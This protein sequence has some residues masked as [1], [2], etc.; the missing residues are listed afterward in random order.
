MGLTSRLHGTNLPPTPTCVPTSAA[1]DRG[2]VPGRCD[3][4]D[5][6]RRQDRSQRPVPPQA[7]RGSSPS[8]RTVPSSPTP[9]ASRPARS[10]SSAMSLNG[11][12]SRSSR[13]TPITF[14]P[15][16]PVPPAPTLVVT[17]STD[18][19][20]RPIVGVTGS[21]LLPE[22]RRDHRRVHRRADG[23][24]ARS[25]AAHR[26]PPWPTPPATSRPSRS[27]RRMLDSGLSVTDCAPRLRACT[28][29]AATDPS[30]FYSPDPPE[31]ARVPLGF[32]PTTTAHPRAAGEPPPT[33]LADQQVVTVSGSKFAG[34]HRIEIVPCRA[35]SV[36]GPDRLP[37]AAPVTFLA[38]GRAG[39]ASSS[40]CPRSSWMPADGPSTAALDPHVHARDRRHRDSAI[41]P[42]PGHLRPAR[43]APRRHVRSR[44]ITEP[45]GSAIA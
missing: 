25:C 41:S 26:R 19:A 17:P 29:R 4:H 22:P 7:R 39:S 8:T 34:G 12:R 38:D 11:G 33:G 27:S 6:R 1:S 18:L 9:T 21:G 5:G 44:S 40:R 35:A 36:F 24:S 2:S 42:C 3:R 14:N 30:T 10:A 13:T 43:S 31:A 16:A 32:D 20:A 15:A 37:P 45:T 23:R 28:F